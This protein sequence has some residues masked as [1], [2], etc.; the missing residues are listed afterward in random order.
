MGNFRHELFVNGISSGEQMF[1]TIDEP[2]MNEA[3]PSIGGVSMA[4]KCSFGL[5]MVSSFFVH[6][7]WFFVNEIATAV[8][9]QH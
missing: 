9:L 7:F 1:I 5:F 3:C 6:A 2:F 8:L 4:G